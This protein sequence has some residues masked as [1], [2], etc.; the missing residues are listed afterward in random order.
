MITKRTDSKVRRARGLISSALITNRLK[1]YQELPLRGILTK[2]DKWI[3]DYGRPEE[4][5]AV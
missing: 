3:E 1:S 2:L 4:R 5:K